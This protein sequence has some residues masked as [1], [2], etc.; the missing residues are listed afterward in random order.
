M[1][2]IKKKLKPGQAII[3]AK[4]GFGKGPALIDK[5]GNIT[6]IDGNVTSGFLTMEIID[7]KQRWTMRKQTEIE[8][9]I[10]ESIF[11]KI[12][13][14]FDAFELTD[15]FADFL[16]DNDIDLV[17]QFTQLNNNMCMISGS[18]SVMADDVELEDTID[19]LII[20]DNVIDA[21]LNIVS[22]TVAL[23]D[24]TNR[25]STTYNNL[26]SATAPPICKVYM[27]AVTIPADGYL[28]FN[29]IGLWE[30]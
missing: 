29:I 10:E 13:S 30:S 15:S 22:Q 28:T 7:G 1:A 3:G 5:D 21:K 27:D 16:S 6:G 26:F 8:L 20:D 23:Y 25:A 11:N 9:N 17:I 24:D 18:T 2:L 14:T 19:M 12:Y 4:C